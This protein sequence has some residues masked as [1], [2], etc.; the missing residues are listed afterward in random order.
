MW[1]NSES[2]NNRNRNNSYHLL[3]AYCVPGTGL[4]LLPP[5]SHFQ[6]LQNL[7]EALII[8]SLQLGNV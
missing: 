4:N 1:P 7:Y 2:A 8:S 3:R 5:L 6:L